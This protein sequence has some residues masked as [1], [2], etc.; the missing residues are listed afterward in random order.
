MEGNG[1]FDDIVGWDFDNNNYDVVGPFYHGTHVAGI[2]AAVTNNSKG[3]AGVAGGWGAT[4]PGVKLMIL[5]VGD[6]APDGSILDDAILYAAANG[7]DIIQMSLTVGESAAI[8]AAIA[9]AHQTDR[10]FIDCA[11]S[12]DS[13]PTVSYPARA[14]YVYA[15]GA[16]DTSDQRWPFSNYG[17][18]LDVVAPGVDIWSARKSNSYGKGSGTSYAAPIVAGIAA[19]TLSYAP[20]IDNSDIEEI[21]ARSADRVGGYSYIQNKTYGSWD[22]EMGYGRVNAYIALLMKT[23]TFPTNT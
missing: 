6:F 7:A 14:K 2:A 22:N 17:D 18:S 9:S 4:S 8:D 16:T 21:I 15:V 1:Y 10:V 20:S 13:S 23:G 3:V 12:N 19:L 5:G 11:S